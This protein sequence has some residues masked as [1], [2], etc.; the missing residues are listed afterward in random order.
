MED[1]TGT[2]IP[3]VAIVFSIGTPVLIILIIAV[4]HL[5]KRRLASIERMECIKRGQPVPFEVEAVKTKRSGPLWGYILTAFGAICLFFGSI[6]FIVNLM[7]GGLGS[8]WDV[9]EDFW[10]GMFLAVGLAM[11]FYHKKH[12]EADAVIKKEAFEVQKAQSEVYL[13]AFTKNMQ[14]QQAANDAGTAPPAPP[15]DQQQS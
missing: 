3:L 14:S 13:D 12:G 8:R 1:W 11:V 5:K 9:M 4:A 2:L 6:D 7:D 10:G 15:A